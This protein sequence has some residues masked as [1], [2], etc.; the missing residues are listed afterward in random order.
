MS[1]DGIEN[2]YQYF[3]SGGKK[4]RIEVRGEVGKVYDDFSHVVNARTASSMYLL[5]PA[6]DAILLFGGSCD[7]DSFVSCRD[8]TV[9]SW[10]L[11]QQPDEPGQDQG[12]SD[13]V[14]KQAK[15]SETR[16]QVGQGR[17]HED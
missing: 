5:S 6:I 2:V 16:A 9:D 13:R 3:F 8:E 12:A 10:I 7:T 17:E 1:L 11:E 4:E 14:V 15:G